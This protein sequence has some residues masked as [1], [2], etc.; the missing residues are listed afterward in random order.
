MSGIIILKM[1]FC[2]SISHWPDAKPRNSQDKASFPQVRSVFLFNPFVTEEARCAVNVSRQLVP[3]T[4]YLWVKF[5]PNMFAN[6]VHLQAMHASLHPNALVLSVHTNAP[7][8]V[9]TSCFPFS[10]LRR[11]PSPLCSPSTQTLLNKSCSPGFISCTHCLD[12]VLP[13]ITQKA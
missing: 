7:F 2:F 12:L 11:P 1:L 13:F 10:V 9:L 4:D 6:F 3:F 5:K 8:P